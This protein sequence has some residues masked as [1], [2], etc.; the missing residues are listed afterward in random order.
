MQTSPLFLFLILSLCSY[1][2]SRL[3]T[4]EDGPFE[5]FEYLRTSLG[6]KAGSNKLLKTVADLF[7]C[8]YCLGVWF[9]ALFSM[10]LEPTGLIQY[11]TYVFGMAG[12]Q[13]FLQ[14]FDDKE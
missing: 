1:R 12:L 7:H 10:V 4:R 2:L 8:P 3:I 6:K 14:S 13:A 5:I 11:F 9:S